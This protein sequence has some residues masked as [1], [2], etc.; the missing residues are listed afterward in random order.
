V[1][2]IR[3]LAVAGVAVVGALVGYVV[4]RLTSR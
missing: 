2:V 1:Q 3:S 4:G